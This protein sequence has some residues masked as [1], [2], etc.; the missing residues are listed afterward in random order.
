VVVPPADGEFVDA[1][2]LRSGRPGP[3]QLL[4]HVLHLERL[5]RLPI[6]AEF[7]GHVPDR[8]GPTATADVVG[9]PP[10]VGGVVG[11]P[12]ELLL[13]HGAAAPAAH[14][15]DLELQVPPG[16]AAREVA[17][18]TGLAV[19]ERPLH[20]PT[21]A[22]GRFF[23]RRMSRRIRALGS[24]KMPR[25]VASGRKPGN[26]KASSSRRGF[27]IRV[28]CRICQPE[29]RDETLGNQGVS[30]PSRVTQYP[31]GWEKNQKTKSRNVY[32]P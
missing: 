11:Q 13:P 18:P 8:R 21:G 25:A 14:A 9:K 5:D 30:G 23:P 24:P 1:D 28:S 2:H 15:P 26:R 10:G 32:G 31:L 16:V 3:P 27:R 12:G 22:A 19:V 29:E 4:A 6:E 20:P 17:H 7:A